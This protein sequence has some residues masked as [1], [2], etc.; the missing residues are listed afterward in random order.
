MRHLLR[1]FSGQAHH[2]DAHAAHIENFVRRKHALA[3]AVNIGRQHRKL[4]QVALH[5]QH[6]GWFV[7]FMVA[8]RHRVVAQQVH[9]FEVRHGILQIRLGHACVDIATV[10]QQAV[11]TAGSNVGTQ[12]INHRFARCH[13]VF[14]IGVFPETAVVVVGVQDSDAVGFVAFRARRCTTREQGHE[15]SHD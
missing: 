5:F 13:A 12:G 8:D 6:G 11:T 7:K 3:A 10:Q 9:A 2:R 1:V 4:G 14:T 15:H